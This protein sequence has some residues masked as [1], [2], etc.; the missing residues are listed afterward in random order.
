MKWRYFDSK[1]IKPTFGGDLDKAKKV[2]EELDDESN[3][4]VDSL[5]DHPE[6]DSQH[7]HS[8][9]LPDTSA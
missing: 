9:R 3:I 1:V 8:Q 6:R 2:I 4:N 5:L 7:N